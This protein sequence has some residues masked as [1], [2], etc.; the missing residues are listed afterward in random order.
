MADC[1][2]V[3]DDERNVRPKQETE[4]PDEGLGDAGDGDGNR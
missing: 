4:E 3:A 2:P 1:M